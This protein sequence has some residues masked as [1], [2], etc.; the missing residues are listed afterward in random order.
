MLTGF[1]LDSAR[2]VNQ[3]EGRIRGKSYTQTPPRAEPLAGRTTP[4]ERPVAAWPTPVE[5]KRVGTTRLD[6]KLT[7]HGCGPH[8]TWA[9]QIVSALERQSV[10]VADIDAAATA[11][12]HLWPANSSPHAPSGPMSPLRS[13]PWRVAQVL[14]TCARYRGPSRCRP[15]RPRP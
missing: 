3:T 7:A 6:A 8:A 14:T 4:P 5:L 12:P 11:L 9:G 1:D 13:R 2:Q 10:T 15:C